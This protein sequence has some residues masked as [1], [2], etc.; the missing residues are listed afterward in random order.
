[1]FAMHGFEA[2]MYTTAWTDL[3]LCVH[4]SHIPMCPFCLPC[5]CNDLC[6]PLLSC[7]DLAGHLLSSWLHACNFRRDSREPFGEN[8]ENILEQIDFILCGSH[9]SE[10]HRCQ[11]PTAHRPPTMGRKNRGAIMN[12]QGRINAAFE[13]LKLARDSG[14]PS[15]VRTDCTMQ[16]P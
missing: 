3:L 14:T 9:F 7:P 8:R 5:H 4:M 13:A 2:C 1:M 11:L 15:D 6:V 16:C 12:G 10:P